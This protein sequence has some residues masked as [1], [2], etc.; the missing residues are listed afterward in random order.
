MAKIERLGDIMHELEAV[1]T[2]MV[3]QHDL[4]HGEILNLVNGYL[5]VH[6]PE[7]KEEYITGGEPKFYYGPKEG[8]RRRKR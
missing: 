6:Y 7:A 2:K 3:K 5:E 4:Q 8:L 1:V